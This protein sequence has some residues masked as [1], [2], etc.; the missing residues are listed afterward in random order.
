MISSIWPQTY[1]LYL[2]RYQRARY[3]LFLR[4]FH[5]KNLTSHSGLEYWSA[6]EKDHPKYVEPDPLA[7]ID[8]VPKQIAYVGFTKILDGA[9]LSG[10]I[11]YSSDIWQKSNRTSINK[12]LG[13]INYT[14]PL[15]AG[16]LTFD[17]KGELDEAETLKSII[18]FRIFR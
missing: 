14:V 6:N 7:R 18:L 12:T 10:R 11:L 13:Q 1:Y 4:I 15:G 3:C 9:A 2:D 16:E 5:R 8:G 17:L